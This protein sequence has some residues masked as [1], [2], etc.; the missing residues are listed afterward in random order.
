MQDTNASYAKW[1]DS[2]GYPRGES[3]LLSAQLALLTPRLAVTITNKA[4]QV[5]SANFLEPSSQANSNPAGFT[6][7][8]KGRALKVHA[9]GPSSVSGP[10]H[11]V[12]SCLLT[13]S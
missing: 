3:Y 8:G 7:K 11:F 9:V 2:Q 5:V 13:F 4:G 6:G 1:Y 10:L 12:A